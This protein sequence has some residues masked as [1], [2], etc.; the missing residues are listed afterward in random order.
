MNYDDAPEPENDTFDD[1]PAIPTDISSVPD[2]AEGEAKVG[3]II[4]FRQLDMS[5]ATNW[6]PQMSEYRVAEVRSVKDHGVINV[7]LAK[8]DRKPRSA[9]SEYDEPRQFSKFEV[10]DL[11]N[12]EGEDD[13]YRELAF[14]ELSDPKLLQPAAQSGAKSEDQNN[15]REGSMSVK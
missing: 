3:A 6:Q 2:L 1:L 12:D 8:R 4:A 13:G 11:A 5:K 10:P 7:L 9:S 14:A 15:T